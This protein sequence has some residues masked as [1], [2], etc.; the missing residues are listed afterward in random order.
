MNDSYDHRIFHFI[1][2]TEEERCEK[3]KQSEAKEWQVSLMLKE[4]DRMNA[5]VEDM[6]LM[7]KPGAPLLKKAYIEDI[8]NEILPLYN[9]TTKDINFNV[10]IKPVPLQLDPRQMTQ[11]LYNLIRNSCE[12]IGGT[13][14]ITIETCIR[15]NRYCMFIKDTGS[16]IPV[17]IQDK[18]FDP[19][20]T[21]KESVTG[22]GLTIV[23]KI[24]ENH[25]GTIEL[26]STSEA[27]TT[28]MISLP[29]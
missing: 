17:E 25:N 29:L 14:V 20:L 16:G 7:A 28:F 11:V 12:A 6:L 19:F 24:I 15:D 3:R 8:L 23:Q 5:I 2:V 26:H 22:L 21:S 13:G 27:G 10:D 4:L 9:Q 18:I 1:D